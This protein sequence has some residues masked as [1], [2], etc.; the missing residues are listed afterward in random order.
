MSGNTIL[1]WLVLLPL[2]G[3][4][5]SCAVGAFFDKRDPKA[6]VLL[7][8]I[9][10]AVTL[11][12]VLAISL[13][14]ALR[15]AQGNPCALTIPKICAMGLTLV[16][17][18]FRGMYLVVTSFAWLTT[19]VFFFW[20]GAG[21]EHQRRYY[22]FAMI[23]LACTLGVFLAA[24]FFTLFVFFEGMSL[25]SYVWVAQEQTKHA[26]AASKTYLAVSIIGGLVL[27]TGILLLWHTTGTLTF[28]ELWWNS[29]IAT[30]R[31]ELYVA[32]GCLLFG[33]GAKAGCWPLHI[34][35]P[36][37][38][39]EAPA[40]ASALLSGILTK[41]GVFGVL[42][43][44][45]RVFVG[46]A[47]WGAVL[48]MLGV[49]TMLVGAIRALFS[50]DIKHMLACSS[51]SQIGF[52]LTGTGVVCAMTGG[53]YAYA[54]GGSVLHMLNHSCFKLIL[55]I[56]AGIVVK[57]LHTRDFN[58]IRGFGRNKP[59][60][61]VLVLIA[62]LGIAGIPGFSGYVSKTLL[63]EA[64]VIC[65]EATE[66]VGYKI[67]EY[68]FLAA[69]GCTFA[70][71]LKL[72]VVLFLRKPSE[73]VLAA[74]ARSR[75][76][77]APRTTL[78]LLSI[79]AGYIF[80][81]GSL[82]EIVMVPLGA[83]VENFTQYPPLR[84]MPHLFSW[85]CLEG[86]LISIGFG[87]LL[88]FFAERPLVMK[89]KVPL[90]E[91]PEYVDRAEHMPGL[92]NN[93]YRPLLLSVLP[94][95]FGTLMRGLELATEGFGKG[96]FKICKSI[97]ALL[98]KTVDALMLL[99]RRTIL[100]PVCEQRSITLGEAICNPIGHVGNAFKKL[101]NVTFGR[102]NP[103]EGDCVEAVNRAM[104]NVTESV[105]LVSRSLSYGLMAF[106]IG[107]IVLLVYILLNLQ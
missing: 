89:R 67:A 11:A 44:S 18:S 61:M 50:T 47:R 33:F 17:D 71:M 23:T 99:L 38:H 81:G 64:I 56:A 86:G 54:I 59:W 51:V 84:S 87:L 12:A 78:V 76:N 92:E 39:P 70:Y 96:V 62:S 77:Y 106:C 69:G 9:G 83:S 90:R 58:K 73:E 30:S 21:E 105:K 107:L 16:T 2:A 34:W 85:E 19:T 97:L 36:K 5:V 22:V 25:A 32:G 43:L 91:T 57:Q 53:G 28:T 27:L 14:V 49:A 31:T 4:L 48:T 8:K 102:K 1:L 60:L 82:P 46:D 80:V 52:I 95:F 66:A 93:L 55:F 98:D 37:A 72:F 74:D 103:R 10:L 79:V 40:S 68:L 20:Y 35:L 42:I 63:H 101:W 7:E 13:I 6:S 29:A 45:G 104:G 24:D 88:Y 94:S 65:H 26:I 100:R 75:K 15:T 41:T 3:G